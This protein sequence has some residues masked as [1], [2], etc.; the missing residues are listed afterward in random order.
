MEQTEIESVLLKVIKIGIFVSLLTPFI[1]GP[2]G[3][4]FVEYPKAVFF[5]SLIEIVFV[6][7]ISLILF[8]K[9]YIPKKSILLTSL[10]LFYAVMFVASIFGINFHRSFFG[11]MPRGE[12]LIMHVHL[13]V[14]FIIITSVFLKREE[15]LNL[16]KVSVLI[17]GLSSLAALLQQ[18]KIAW[19][20][21]IDHARL[22]GTLSNPNL[23]ACYISLSIFITIFLLAIEHNKKLK[24]L[25]LSLIIL[26]CYTLF[27]SGTRGSW[28]GLIFGLVFILFFNFLKLNYKIRISII[29]GILIVS[30][31]IILVFFNLQQIRSIP[32]G[33]VISR[34]INVN[35]SGRIE[36][37]QA[38]MA[39]IKDR[40]ILG[41][42]FESFAFVSDKYYEK[43]LPRGIYFDRPHNKIIEILIYS[44]MLGLLSYLFVFS[45]IF[46][47]IFKYTKLWED[48]SGKSKITYTSILAAFFICYFV[49]NIFAFDNICTYILFFIVVGFI[50]TFKENSLE[51]S[52]IN[53]NDRV[54]SSKTKNNF[55]AIKIV[56]ILFIF[57]TTAYV[58]YQ[59]NLK[60]TI[61][62]M[63]FSTS[64][65]YEGVDPERAF[66]AYK[67]GIGMKTIYDDD[68]RLTFTD[69]TLY[70]LEND[71]IRDAK[72]EAVETL[73]KIK[74]FLYK[75]IENQD[76]QVNHLYQFIAR[77]NEQEYMQYKNLD[78]L[79]EMEQVLS[80]AILFNPNMETI[81]RLMG[82]LRIFQNN[83]SEGEE[84]IKEVC[85]FDNCTDI[86]LYKRIAGA[87]LK[88]GEIDFALKNFEKAIDIERE[89]RKQGIMTAIVTPELIDYVAS[90]YY[91]K[92][93]DLQSC[94]RIYEKGSEIYPMYADV[95]DQR[96]KII[97]SESYK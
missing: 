48:Y 1:M 47:L 86:E 13:L 65:V 57:L 89:R 79:N 39:A 92:L 66:Y 55:T 46:Y 49:Q 77:I 22:S 83:Y 73:S 19:F 74:P 18:A 50:N 7:Y 35:L 32:G 53:V 14:F 64:I 94:R 20:Y 37:W 5:R 16:F 71:F 27:F 24:I 54:I 75:A 34:I 4:N 25:W 28:I 2:F 78:S 43:N 9:K 33:P 72:K 17:S 69:R 82:D 21:A 90:T 29:I 80:N 88:T 85:I 51:G 23:F 81:Y 63:C 91:E 76:E 68:L 95:F 84:Y 44:G 60:P 12:G 93:N 6:F 52:F 15:W 61:A 38:S 87:Y 31:L 10:L 58:M 40:P 97:T 8:N 42:G 67:Q 3:I 30:A 56:S 36:S 62:A 70:L 59:V 45:V 26:N 96:F 41:W 11:D